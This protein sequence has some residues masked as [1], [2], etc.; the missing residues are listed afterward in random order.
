MAVVERLQVEAFVEQIQS[1]LTEQGTVVAAAPEGVLKN[2]IDLIMANMENIDADEAAAIF[3]KITEAALAFSTGNWFA[4][5]MGLMA[6]FR[7]Y[8]KAIKTPVPGP[9]V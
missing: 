4:G 2:L 9:V 1:D 6:A 5:T 7:L 8:R 3:A